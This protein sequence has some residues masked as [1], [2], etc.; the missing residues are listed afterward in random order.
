M[1]GKLMNNYYY[2]KSGKGD[3]KKEDL[4]ENR[5][6]L[7][8]D[9]LKTRLSHLCRLNLMHVAI[10]LPTIIVLMMGFMSFLN[11][12]NPVVIESKNEAGETEYVVKVDEEGNEIL[13]F[14]E[15]GMSF[16][17]AID[18]TLLTTLL[19]LIPCIL[20]TGPV[21]AGVSYVTRNWARDE[22]AFIWTDFRDA[23]KANWKQ[24]LVIS[25]ITSVIPVIAYVCWNFYGKLAASSTFMIVPQM[26]VL[27][28]TIIWAI[29]VTYMY[30]LLV[31][32]DLKIKGI[33]KNGLLLG[34]ARLPQSIGIRLLHCVPAGIG[35]LLCWFWHPLYGALLLIGYYFLIGYA[36][37]R[38]ITASYTNGVFDKFI[39]SKIEGAVVNR[40]LRSDEDDEEDDEEQVREE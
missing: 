22:H 35:F 4:P 25:G 39:N 15:M 18:G 28:L 3:F 5:W 38:F 13:G 19:L 23:V 26:L 16:S 1:F 9:T 14:T 17:D 30:P 12:S 2:G 37:S 7:F 24:G 40:G 27:M 10:W 21:T 29:S 20:I 31:S 33:L 6:Q 36:L 32:Y 34:I 11:I 8:L